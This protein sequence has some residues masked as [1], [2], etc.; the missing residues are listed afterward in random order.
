MRFSLQQW[1][2]T[3]LSQL[4]TS[5]STMMVTIWNL[6]VKFLSKARA[7]C[8]PGSWWARMVSTRKCLPIQTTENCILSLPLLECCWWGQVWKAF[9]LGQC[10]VNW[11]LNWWNMVIW[12][13]VGK[14]GFHKKMPSKTDY[15]ELHSITTFAGMLI[16]R[17]GM[18]SFLV[19]AMY[20]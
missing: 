18:K 13:L 11:F 5:W 10:M 3:C 16:M 6:E 17:A 9:W 7:T 15:R 8:S 19:R 2:F 14:D 1:K 20:G 12:F 4:G